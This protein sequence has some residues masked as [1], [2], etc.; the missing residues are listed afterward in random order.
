MKKLWR[1]ALLFAAAS[2]SA[3]SVVQQSLPMD[4]DRFVTNPELN[5][6]HEINAKASFVDSAS[7]KLYGVHVGRVSEIHS[8]IDYVLSPDVSK[9]FIPR[10]GLSW[11]RFSFNHSG[12]VPLPNVLQSGSVVAGF[13]TTLS[14]D[15]LLRFE[16]K[17]GIYSDFKDIDE[18][19][20]NVPFIIGASW[21]VDTD[22]QIFAGL[23]VDLFREYPV[24]PGLGIRWRFAEDWTLMLVPPD[25]RII[26]SIDKNLQVFAGLDVKGMNARVGDSFGTVRGRPNLDNALL[27][28]TEIRVGAGVSYK[29]FDSIMLD[30]EGGYMVYRRYDF[31]RANVHLESEPAPYVQ[32]AVKG[33][34]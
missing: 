29:V 17:P 21:L 2:A 1:T 9:D 30:L 7:T 16:A 3:Q 34:F 31:F 18:N 15:W 14:E 4:M 6:T 12:P 25:P 20:V 26:Y 10:A 23:S 13:D 32:F 11:E 24:L 28:L 33:S 19:D 5:I 27:N 22:L 8:A